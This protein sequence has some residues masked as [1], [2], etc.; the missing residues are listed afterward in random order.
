M[1][2]CKDCKYCKD[3][4]RLGNLRGAFHCEHPNMRAILRYFNEH[5]LSKMPGFIAFSVSSKRY[6]PDIKTSPAWCP[7]KLEKKEEGG[8]C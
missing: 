2:K 7:Y 4:A 6:E 1:M 3:R 5:R 8:K